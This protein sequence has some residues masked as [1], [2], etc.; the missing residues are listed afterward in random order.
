MS[1]G[2]EGGNYKAV[3]PW[4]QAPYFQACDQV[5]VSS[6]ALAQTAQVMITSSQHI[7]LPARRYNWGS[8][9]AQCLWLHSSPVFLSLP[10]IFWGIR[11]SL[12]NSIMHDLVRKLGILLSVVNNISLCLLIEMVLRFLPLHWKL[13]HFYWNCPPLP[14][15]VFFFFPYCNRRSYTSIF[16]RDFLF[17]I[18]FKVP[19]LSVSHNSPS[20]TPLFPSFV[21]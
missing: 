17:I 15:S 19:L 10:K 8:V 11:Q 9:Q 13:L 2:C 12:I 14:F 5:Y 20:W 1:L 3:C 18:R 4:G 7:G 21:Q 6:S 16:E